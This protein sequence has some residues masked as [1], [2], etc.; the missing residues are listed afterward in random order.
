[1]GSL[2]PVQ[3]MDEISSREQI[4]TTAIH[5]STTVAWASTCCCHLT[6]PK[7]TQKSERSAEIQRRLLNLHLHHV[8][9]KVYI[10]CFHN[11]LNLSS[12]TEFPT[13]LRISLVHR[14]HLKAESHSTGNGW[15]LLQESATESSIA[16]KPKFLHPV[17]S[18]KKAL[19]SDTIVE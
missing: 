11:R 1:M 7:I 15:G 19:R 6:P 2:T 4:V 14:A 3:L 5:D 10:L 13:C 8:Q 18:L 9:L 17:W 12:A 16:E